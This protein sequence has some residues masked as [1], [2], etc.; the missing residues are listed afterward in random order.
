MLRLHGLVL[1]AV[2]WGVWQ[3]VDV[4]EKAVIRSEAFLETEKN[5]DVAALYKTIGEVLLLAG[6]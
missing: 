1:L 2:D 5:G 3:Y 4:L 6:K